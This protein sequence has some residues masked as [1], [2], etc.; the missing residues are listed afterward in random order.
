MLGVSRP[1][2]SYLEGVGM[3]SALVLGFGRFGEFAMVSYH[4]L[5]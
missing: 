3:E 2:W 4:R 1:D 5:E